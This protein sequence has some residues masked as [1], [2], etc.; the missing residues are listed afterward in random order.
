[1]ASSPDGP[2]DPT[3]PVKRDGSVR[4]TD[5]F[6]IFSGTPDRDTLWL[7]AVTGL[8]KAR[9]RMQEIA[10]DKPGEYFIFQ[11]SAVVGM[12][13]NRPFEARQKSPRKTG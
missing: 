4:E 2:H 5:T 1:M 11:A 6:D 7:E 9:Q 8:D 12:L 13:D 3:N 10:N